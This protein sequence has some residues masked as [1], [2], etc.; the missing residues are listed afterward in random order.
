ML[1]IYYLLRVLYRPILQE[2]FIF[3][4]CYLCYIYLKFIY[5]NALYLSFV[6]YV[7]FNYNL[8]MFTFINSSFNNHLYVIFSNIQK[9]VPHSGE[10]LP[11]NIDIRIIASINCKN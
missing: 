8:Y 9:Q 4:I 2:Y 6:I 5:K 1:Y 7:L 10:Y 3:I 11:Y